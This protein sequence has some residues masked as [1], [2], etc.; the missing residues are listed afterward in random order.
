MDR[1]VEEEE[2]GRIVRSEELDTVAERV[3]RLLVPFRAIV[4]VVVVVVGRRE[5]ERVGVVAPCLCSSAFLRE[6]T[7]PEPVDP[8]PPPA[9]VVVVAVL[10]PEL[11][12]LGWAG[13]AVVVRV[14][15]IVLS[16]FSSGCFEFAVTRR[17][18]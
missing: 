6:A 5:F 9:P 7:I 11:T 13:V 8:P 2:E 1:L 17:V 12:G 14:E 15:R 16:L 18:F 4:V 3:W 10:R